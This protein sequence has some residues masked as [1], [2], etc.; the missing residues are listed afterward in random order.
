MSPTLTQGKLDVNRN[1]RDRHAGWHDEPDLNRVEADV[2]TGPDAGP[3]TDPRSPLEAR[4]APESTGQGMAALRGIWARRFSKDFDL[5]KALAEIR[6]WR[7]D[8][9]KPGV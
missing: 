9:E 8:P 4:C 7:L 6:T 5:G 3:W 1:L 2:Y